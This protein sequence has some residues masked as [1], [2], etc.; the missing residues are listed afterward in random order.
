MIRLPC[1]LGTP[2]TF[3]CRS[4]HI[5]SSQLHSQALLQS[6]ARTS[7]Y[8]TCEYATANG[9][10]RK[11]V[12]WDYIVATAQHARVTF[13]GRTDE[14]GKAKPPPFEGNCC[15]ATLF[16]LNQQRCDART[17]RPRQVSDGLLAH[18]PGP[19]Q[20]RHIVLQLRRWL[21]LSS[22]TQLVSSHCSQRK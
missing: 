20:Q 1:F 6:N 17:R 22:S 7:M 19:W 15:A 14:S 16:V 10:S 18:E 5:I 13:S 4:L 8:V 3:T 11:Q 2:S 9:L 21:P 12:M